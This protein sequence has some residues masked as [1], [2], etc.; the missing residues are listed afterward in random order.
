VSASSTVLLPPNGS[1][2]DGDAEAVLFAKTTAER[3][4]DLRRELAA[5]RPNDRLCIGRFDEADVLD[6]YAWRERSSG[7]TPADQLRRTP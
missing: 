1:V 3:Y 6:A 2:D 7:R 5:V 4:P